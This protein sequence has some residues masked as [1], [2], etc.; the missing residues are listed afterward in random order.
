MILQWDVFDKI[1]SQ[2]VF[3]S[4]AKFNYIITTSG[5]FWKLKFKCGEKVEKA[6]IASFEKQLSTQFRKKASDFS[7]FV[8][9]NRL[10]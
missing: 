7:S 2:F 3:F 1:C 10:I 4:H 6:Q 5:S 9:F 8:P